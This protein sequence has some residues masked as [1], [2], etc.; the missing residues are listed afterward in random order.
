[1]FGIGWTE[2]IVIALVLLVIV[3]P[4]HLPGLFRK[5]GRLTAEFRSASR[6]LRNQIEIEA[7][8][9][10]SP[11]KA[12]RDLQSDMIKTVSEPYDQVVKEERELRRELQEAVEENMD[13]QTTARDDKD[14]DPG[15]G[16][17]G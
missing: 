9:I 8:D 1:V 11:V 17:N 16:S 15:P 6:E 14:G 10:E 12:V 2:F 7:E 5:L 13:D 3:G 4:K